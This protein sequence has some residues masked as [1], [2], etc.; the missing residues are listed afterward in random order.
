MTWQVLRYS[1]FILWIWIDISSRK[2][3]KSIVN[4]RVPMK[5]YTT[6]KTSFH[7]VWVKQVS[8]LGTVRSPPVIWM[9]RHLSNSFQH[10][11]GLMHVNVASD[12]A[13]S[14]RRFQGHDLPPPVYLAIC[15]RRLVLLGPRSMDWWV[16]VHG[17]ISHQHQQRPWPVKKTTRRSQSAQYVGG[18]TSRTQGLFFQHGFC[19]PF[20]Q[21]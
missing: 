18:R 17:T 19:L 3:L 14:T 5:A 7:K 11:C 15:C 9:D 8:F 1:I 20:D 2:K 4:R 10:Q 6:L 16:R 21:E 12:A 13:G